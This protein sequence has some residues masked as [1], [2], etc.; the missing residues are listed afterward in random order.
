M[1]ERHEIR[2]SQPEGKRVLFSYSVAANVPYDKER[3]ELIVGREP[4]GTPNHYLIELRHQHTITAY[5]ID[6][7]HSLEEASQKA[8]AYA[9]R[10]A[11]ER[12]SLERKQSGV[13]VFL[14]DDT[15][16]GKK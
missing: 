4:I 16:R 5:P 6:I 13:E 12:I 11:N 14:V 7:G 2:I 15:I 3:V 9:V 10:M 8:Y 1:A